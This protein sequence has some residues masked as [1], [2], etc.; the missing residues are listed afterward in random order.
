MHSTSVVLPAEHRDRL[1]TGYSRFLPGQEREMAPF[2]DLQSLAP[3]G[4]FS[5]TVEDLVR[6]AALQFRDDEAGLKQVLKASTLREMHRVHWLFPNWEGGL[7]LGF[8]VFRQPQRTL[9]THTRSE[10]TDPGR[11]RTPPG[12]KLRKDVVEYVAFSG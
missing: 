4:N 7:G 3:A 6:F 5:S 1:A 11:P 9:P 8:M 2:T 12:C 10:Q